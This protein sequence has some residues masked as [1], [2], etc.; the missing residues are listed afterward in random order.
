MH[1]R[2]NDTPAAAI[3][4]PTMQHDG[5]PRIST[6]HVSCSFTYQRELVEEVYSVDHRGLHGHYQWIRDL[7][8]DG[9]ANGVCRGAQRVA[10]QESHH[11]VGLL[12]QSANTK[13]LADPTTDTGRQ[14]DNAN[15]INKSQCLAPQ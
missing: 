14:H 5:Q 13:S 3:A 6:T 1:H 8:R 4:R 11:A 7:A 9:D 10:Q 2:H 12:Q 15:D